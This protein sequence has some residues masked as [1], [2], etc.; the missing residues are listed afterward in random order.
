M[1]SCI[2][3]NCT[4]VSAE[5]R[6][7]KRQKLLEKKYKV[8]F[9]RLPKDPTKRQKWLDSLCI[10]EPRGASPMI[11]SIHFPEN[12]FDRTSQSCVR[13]REFAIPYGPLDEEFHI[14]LHKSDQ[15]RL[16]QSLKQ[17]TVSQINHQEVEDDPEEV[18][19]LDEE[20]FSDDDEKFDELS[21]S[22]GIPYLIDDTSERKLYVDRSTSVSPR[23][24]INDVPLKKEPKVSVTRS[25]SV[26][27]QHTEDSTKTQFFRTVLMN[28][29]KMYVHK[30]KMLQQKQRRTANKLAN[31]RAI[32][33]VLKKKNLLGA[34]ELANL[35]ENV[36]AS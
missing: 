2:A 17:K 22:E 4:N 28:T 16:P 26:S 23:D 12:A 9:H 35:Q 30:I 11:C 21:I 27:P 13:L 32:L 5:A 24:F 3:L 15:S 10:P 29:K 34:K 14:T 33:N 1:P 18:K 8:T 25:T 36:L 31:M 20:N 7:S 19:Y 6:K